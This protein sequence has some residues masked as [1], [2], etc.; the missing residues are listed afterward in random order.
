[1]DHELDDS[2]HEVVRQVGGA[3]FDPPHG[4]ETVHRHA[5]ETRSEAAD[6]AGELLGY[7]IWALLG[8]PGR[9]LADGELEDVLQLAPIVDP[10]E[11]V[12]IGHL[13]D[14]AR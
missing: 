13:D 9:I 4:Y 12:V 5:R 14:Q 10:V 1:M 6:E 8:P 11:P 3:A 2:G 7:D